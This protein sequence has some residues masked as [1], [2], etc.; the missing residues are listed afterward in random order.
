MDFQVLKYKTYFFHSKLLQGHY[1]IILTLFKL[2]SHFIKNKNI[3]SGV[4]SKLNVSNYVAKRGWKIICLLLFNLI[5]YITKII[6]LPVFFSLMAMKWWYTRRKT[7]LT[8]LSVGYKKTLSFYFIFKNIVSNYKAI[9]VYFI[10]HWLDQIHWNNN[11]FLCLTSKN[12]R[13]DCKQN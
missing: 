3:N 13:R 6:K 8:N 7:V 12:T 5:I 11:D 9:T 4:K 2:F 10:I 1:W